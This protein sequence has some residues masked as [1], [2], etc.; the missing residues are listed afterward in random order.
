MLL[1][2]VGIDA[3]KLVNAGAANERK[4]TTQHSAYASLCAYCVRPAGDCR[5]VNS[6]IGQPVNVLPDATGRQK[7]AAI[8]SLVASI[9]E[10]F[11]ILKIQ[12]CLQRYGRA[13]DYSDEQQFVSSV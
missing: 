5:Q 11:S 1:A 4:T 12:L 6:A 8:S 3:D 2:M 10:R 9:P 7:Q 13:C